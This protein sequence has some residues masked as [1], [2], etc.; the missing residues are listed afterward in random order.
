MIYRVRTTPKCVR[1][2]VPKGS[3]Y[4]G[5]MTSFNGADSTFIQA[6]CL[7]DEEFPHT[8]PKEGSII[9]F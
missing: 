6:L 9:L 1:S 8:P 4:P 2:R 5:V 3:Y 7:D